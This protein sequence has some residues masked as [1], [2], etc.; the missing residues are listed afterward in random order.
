MGQVKK[1]FLMILRFKVNQE[2]FW[3]VYKVSIQRI[4]RYLREEG[5]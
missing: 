1:V 2:N 3:V 5:V 4:K